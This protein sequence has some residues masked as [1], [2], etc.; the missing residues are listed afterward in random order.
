MWQ[1][2]QGASSYLLVGMGDAHR[3]SL[4]KKLDAAG[5]PHFKIDEELVRQQKAIDAAWVP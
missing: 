5:I 4:Q 3:V 2:I 1:K